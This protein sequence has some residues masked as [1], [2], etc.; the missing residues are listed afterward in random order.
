MYPSKSGSLVRTQDK[1]ILEAVKEGSVSNSM[2]DS[3]REAYRV[4]A[5]E[6][7]M[8]RFM[9]QAEKYRKSNP[10]LAYRYTKA[11]NMVQDKNMKRL[12][13]TGAG[14]HALPLAAINTANAAED[15]YF[16]IDGYIDHELNNWKRVNF[17]EPIF[18]KKGLADKY[19]KATDPKVKAA[20]QEE[21]VQ[22]LE[23]M[24]K[25]AP[26][27]MKNV[28][29]DFSDNKFTARS[30]TIPIDQ[31]DDAG[32]K[33][34]FTK[35]NRINQK[36]ITDM[37]DAVKL[38]STGRIASIGDK[39]IKP[40]S[41]AAKVPTE[42]LLISGAQTLTPDGYRFAGVDYGP[43]R[44]AQFFSKVGE[45]VARSP[46]GVRMPLQL[47]GK[48]ATGV[49]RFL[50]D[51][52]FIPLIPLEMMVTSAYQFEKNKDN[53]MKSLKENP[54]V[55]EMAKKYNMSA[56]DVRNAILEKYRRAV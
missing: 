39:F 10:E 2:P 43:G 51:P 47:T 55:T 37:P 29:F 32:F 6:I 1:L 35:G 31:L 17:D 53:I 3:I 12:G 22:R 44:T 41:K 19:H 40:I 49:G 20:L 26:E 54:M 18:R 11:F 50:A 7:N 8:S 42:P 46:T 33:T 24:K 23:Y 9:A 15:T 16:K 28:T 13:I 27:L 38:T 14:E 56:A 52:F 5:K 4:F 25:R 36:F 30:S 21:I 48:L 34:L 45:K